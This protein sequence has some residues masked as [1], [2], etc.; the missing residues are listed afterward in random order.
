MDE[1]DVNKIT[2]I[3]GERIYWTT[4][5]VDADEEPM[6]ISDCEIS[7]RGTLND[8]T[9]YEKEM[10]LFD[11]F[12]IRFRADEMVNELVDRKLE[13]RFFFKFPDDTERVSEKIL[14]VVKK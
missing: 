12:T 3:V 7:F 14:I 2:H 11:N 4:Q 13:G 6:N 9:S 1:K 10:S 8:K 5:L